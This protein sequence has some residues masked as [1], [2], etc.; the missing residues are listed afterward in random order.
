MSG[1]DTAT[2]KDLEVC[3]DRLL[4]YARAAPSSD[5]RRLIGVR[6]EDQQALATRAQHERARLGDDRLVIRASL[7]FSSHCRQMC[8][9]CGM[10][11]R[12]KELT[13]YR[14]TLQEMSEVVRATIDLGVRDLHLASGE[15]RS[16]SA[17]DIARV[18]EL[19]ASLGMEVTL[20][21]G[22]RALSDYRTWFDA[23]ARRY[24]LKLETTSEPLFAAART[25]TRLRTRIAHLLYLRELGYKIGSGVIVGLPGQTLDD[26][27][28]DLTVLQSLAPDM[29]SVSR[30]LP[31]EVSALRGQPEG[32]HD[33]TLNFIA[34]LRVCLGTRTLRIPAGATLGHHQAD[35]LLFGANVLSVHVTPS[36]VSD[37]YSAD[38][39]TT[40]FV[41]GMAHVL[42]L[43]SEAGLSTT[44][45][46]VQR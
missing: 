17:D 3:A 9:F 8:S 7:E 22:Q 31:N 35:A 40:R 11:A 6:G 44:V 2:I 29:A 27:V 33:T 16:F 30:F 4:E 34:L 28:Q 5:Y 18:A 15:D 19:A 1:S 38:R 41:S 13:R 14:L 45:V 23:G 12:N 42:K 36:A 26:L 32:D 39:I 25:G 24:V 46:N 21:V 10:S 43:A 37:L 20:V